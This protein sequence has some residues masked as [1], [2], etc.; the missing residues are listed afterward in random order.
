MFSLCCYPHGVDNPSDVPP[1]ASQLK[2]S[3]Q[4]PKVIP[5][6]PTVDSGAMRGSK[7][8]TEII[9]NLREMDDSSHSLSS[10][11][12]SVL[13]DANSASSVSSVELNAY[14]TQEAR[15]DVQETKPAT[16][17]SEIGVKTKS[18]WTGDG[19]ILIN[20]NQSLMSSSDDAIEYS[21]EL[22]RAEEPLS[23]DTFKKLNIDI[24]LV[25]AEASTEVNEAKPQEPKI[26]RGETAHFDFVQKNVSESAREVEISPALNLNSLAVGEYDISDSGEVMVTKFGE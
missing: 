11:E 17:A 14:D 8:G 5:H 16:Q 13:A 6:S 10:L 21:D 1:I 22:S 20:D 4:A 24:N 15:L 18:L 25:N 3:E 12:L 26:K 7:I 19:Q 23:V 2:P 9:I